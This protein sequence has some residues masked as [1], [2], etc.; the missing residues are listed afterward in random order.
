MFFLLFF[1]FVFSLL[2]FVCVWV[3]VCMRVCVCSL[4]L[5]ISPEL[6]RVLIVEIM[7]EMYTRKYWEY[8][9]IIWV[10]ML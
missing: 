1:R 3:N 5:V 10:P 2:A 6:Q 7:Y 9:M 8:T 4:S